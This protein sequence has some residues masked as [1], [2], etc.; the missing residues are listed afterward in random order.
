MARRPETCR[1]PALLA[2][3]LPPRFASP[4]HAPPPT[5]R[6]LNRP[7]SSSGT[8]GA[9]FKFSWSLTRHHTARF[10]SALVAGAWR[11]VAGWPWGGQSGSHSASLSS[12]SARR[13][14]LYQILCSHHRFT[15]YMV[16]LRYVTSQ[17]TI[18]FVTLC[19][20]LILRIFSKRAWVYGVSK[21]TMDAV[22]MSN[23]SAFRMKFSVLV[24]TLL[25]K[26]TYTALLTR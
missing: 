15:L 12:L 9:W 19:V 8:L 13:L 22:V 5:P 23:T 21:S 14:S 11:G 18:C 10:M 7:H 16:S 1:A 26:P 3:R 20:L 2:H 25:V 4:R 6:Q 24:T 17:P